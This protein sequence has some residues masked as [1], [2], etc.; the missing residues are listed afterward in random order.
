MSF[1]TPQLHEGE[2]CGGRV[3]PPFLCSPD[4]L[5]IHLPQ[6]LKCYLPL[7]PL[8]VESMLPRLVSNTHAQMSLQTW[9]APGITDHLACLESRRETSSCGQSE[10]TKRWSAYYNSFKGHLLYRQG[11]SKHAR[12]ERGR[13]LSQEKCLPLKY[14][15]Q[16]SIPSTHIKSRPTC[17]PPTHTHK[18]IHTASKEINKTFKRRRL[19]DSL[20][21]KGVCPCKPGNP[22]DQTVG[23]NQFPQVVLQHLLKW[24]DVTMH[25]CPGQSSTHSHMQ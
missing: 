1:S 19:W 12:K 25:A 21:E 2:C 20:A 9:E 15:D 5:W 3:V 14:G 17:A 8:L 13:W 6:T 7:L 24:C 23:E 10:P 11:K 18:H 4:W 16:S 22:K